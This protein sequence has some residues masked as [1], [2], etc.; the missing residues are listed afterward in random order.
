MGE[1]VGTPSEDDRSASDAEADLRELVALVLRQYRGPDWI[2]ES[3]LSR[4][5][6]STAERRQRNDTALRT[7][8]SNFHHGIEDFLE[9]E[10]VRAIINKNW[11]LFEIALGPD[12]THFN[13]FM[14]RF[15]RLRNPD[16]HGRALRPFE[17]SLL[18]GIAGDIRN[19][20]T[21]YRSE[22]DPMGD[23]YPRIERVVDSLG[24]S[25]LLPVPGGSIPVTVTGMQVKL[26]QELI[27]DCS[28]WNPGS[29]RLLWTLQ[30][31]DGESASATGENVQLRYT[32]LEDDVSEAFRIGIKMRSDRKYHRADGLD[33][34]GSFQYIVRPP[35]E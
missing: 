10:D 17:R 30:S 15:Q 25:M 5:R 29:G 33:G 26:G 3:G 35:V 7:P 20:V 1:H 12:K 24:N 23:P 18:V 34:I 27:Y 32:V 28:A 11:S 6:I 16:A 14:E 4:D 19:R 2:N 9:L 22:N 13:A 8:Y 31:H 21:I